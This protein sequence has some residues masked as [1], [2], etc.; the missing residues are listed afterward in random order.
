MQAERS[1]F[2][3]LMPLGRMLE[4]V[5]KTTD[6]KSRGSYRRVSNAVEQLRQPEER[7]VQ[8][9]RMEEKETGPTR[10]SQPTGPGRDLIKRTEDEDGV[11]RRRPSKKPNPE[12]G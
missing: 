8:K 12:F 10:V 2:I 3:A 11:R 1:A 4:R 6:P 9:R 5:S 7:L